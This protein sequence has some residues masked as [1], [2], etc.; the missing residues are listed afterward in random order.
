M[1]RS[2]IVGNLLIGIA[3]GLVSTTVFGMIHLPLFD[4]AAS[5][6]GS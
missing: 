5:Y 6:M 2:F 4:F 3:L 1:A